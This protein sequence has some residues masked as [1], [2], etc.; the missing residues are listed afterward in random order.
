[1]T[2]R[3]RCARGHFLP[4]TGDCRCEQPRPRWQSDLWGQG[5]TA[6]QRH[7]IRTVPITGRYL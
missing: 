4:A 3:P 1:M 7:S 5:L 2:A 6:R